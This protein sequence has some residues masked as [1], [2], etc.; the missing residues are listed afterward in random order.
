MTYIVTSLSTEAAAIER[1]GQL[2]GSNIVAST[3]M[4]HVCVTADLDGEY[5]LWNDGAIVFLTPSG[6]M[7]QAVLDAIGEDDPAWAIDF[8]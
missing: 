2:G 1:V 8:A 7:E 6:P 5:D 4:G 3:V